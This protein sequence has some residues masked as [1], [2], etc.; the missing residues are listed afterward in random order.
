MSGERMRVR[1]AGSD[2]LEA[3]VTPIASATAARASV[4]AAPRP[5]PAVAGTPAVSIAYDPKVSAW[6]ARLGRIQ[7]ENWDS[8]HDRVTAAIT[9]AAT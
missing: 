2:D 1:E 9:H 6:A 4:A 8:L 7:R 5:S 3:V